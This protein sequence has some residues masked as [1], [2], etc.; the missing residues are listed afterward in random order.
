M[1]RRPAKSKRKRSRIEWVEKGLDI[2]EK[3]A[4]NDIRYKRHS[5]R[6]GKP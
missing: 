5:A 4:H 6:K 3:A 1:G 2:I